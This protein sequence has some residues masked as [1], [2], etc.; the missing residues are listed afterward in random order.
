LTESPAKVWLR[1]T[2]A[3]IGALPNV[4]LLTR[5]TAFAYLPHNMVALV[6]RLTD[7]LPDPS[8]SLPRDAALAV[9]AAEVVLATGAIERP[10]VFPGND[11]P[12]IML[13]GSA[14]TY[15]QRYGVLPGARIAIVTAHDEAYRAALGARGGRGYRRARG[16]AP[17]GQRRPAA[18][19]GR[20]GLAIRT[21]STAIGTR[22]DRRITAGPR[23]GGCGWQG[24]AWRMDPLRPL[25]VCGGFTRACTCSRNR[26]AN[27]AGIPRPR[28]SCPP[29]PPR[30]AAA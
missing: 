16:P 19:R 30:P 5:T 4:T 10:L 9:R 8:P 17:H 2:L 11:R 14:R 22:G 3:E 1:S 20:A 12:G 26:A 7:H 6:E 27:C 13:A 18:S 28:Y 24:G 25:L 15:L 23:D 29:L 21:G